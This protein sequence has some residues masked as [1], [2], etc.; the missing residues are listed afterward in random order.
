M[1]A[2]FVGCHIFINGTHS[3]Q[4]LIHPLVDRS[5]SMITM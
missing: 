4:I 5:N 2:R 1:E 3:L